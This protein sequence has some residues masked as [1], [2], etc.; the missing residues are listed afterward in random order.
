MHAVSVVVA[1]REHFLACRS[2][3]DGVL[4]LGH[5]RALYIT[6]RRV[7]LHDT[8]IAQIAQRQQVLLL[9]RPVDPP[10]AEGER[11]EILVDEVEEL[12]R[13][14]QTQRNMTYVEILHVMGALEVLLD[15]ALS[16]GAER[17]Y[18]EELALLH[19]RRFAALDDRHRFASVDLIRADRMAVQIAARFHLVRLAVDL[20]FVRLHHLLACGANVTQPGVDAC[21]LDARISRLAHRLRQ[22]VELRVKMHGPRRVDDPPVDVRAKIDLAHI[23]VL[24]DGLVA[25]VGRPM[26]SDMVERAPCWECN[27]CLEAVLLNEGAV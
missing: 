6:E 2:Q 11:V 18:G 17:L 21:C 9:A 26:G 1:L 23:T 20:D 3:E 4:V 14:W 16:S 27:A 24:Q 5:V 12:L 22:R 13:L 19:A 7:R 8:H 15:I 10:A 25:R